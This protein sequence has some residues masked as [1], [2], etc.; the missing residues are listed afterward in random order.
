M[1]TIVF[2]PYFPRHIHVLVGED[3]LRLFMTSGAYSYVV[4]DALVDEVSFMEV[5]RDQ[6]ETTLFILEFMMAHTD[7]T[8]DAGCLHFGPED[9][10][11]STYPLWKAFP[12]TNGF[13]LVFEYF[14]DDAGFR[15]VVPVLTSL[16][17]TGGF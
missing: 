14:H 13:E 10:Q 15:E 3:E 17:T 7:G 16:L 6:Y 9:T 8:W 1:T 4:P 12:F 5:Q 2:I 11:M